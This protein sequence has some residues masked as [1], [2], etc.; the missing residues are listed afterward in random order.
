MSTWKVK[1]TTLYDYRSSDNN[2]VT[3]AQFDDAKNDSLLVTAYKPEKVSGNCKF[4]Y[5]G[6]VIPF[7]TNEGKYGL[8][9]VIHADE[10]EDGVI[11]I[12]I[13]VQ[14]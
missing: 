10:K 9:K 8:I 13:K 7:K 12:A 6:K 3:S 5:T 1:K 14:K 2:L 4:G 11:E